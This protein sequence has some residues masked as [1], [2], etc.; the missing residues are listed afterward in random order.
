MPKTVAVLVGSL[1]AASIHGKLAKSLQELASGRLVFD[2]LDLGGLPHYNDDLWSDPPASVTRMK[3]QVEAADG[4]LILSPEYNRGLPGLVANAFDWGSRPY[5]KSVWTGKPAA[6]AGAT[7]GATG[8][9]AGQQHARLA[10]LNLGMVPMIQPEIYI[11][12]TAERFAE[13]GSI[14]SD[15]TRKLLQGFVDSFADWIDRHG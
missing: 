6:I 11:T 9:A 12:W 2:P 1:R 7:T 4:V 15:D 8:T 10:A 13:D 5:G 14:R 3:A